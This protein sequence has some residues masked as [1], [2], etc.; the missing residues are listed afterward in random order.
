MRQGEEGR[1]RRRRRKAGPSFGAT[2]G[3]AA[4]VCLDLVEPDACALYYSAP[5][6]RLVL[7]TLKRKLT[8]DT[9]AHRPDAR[10]LSRS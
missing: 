4:V 3:G 1:G 10:S 2:H 7:S 5:S 6:R 8:R 9:M